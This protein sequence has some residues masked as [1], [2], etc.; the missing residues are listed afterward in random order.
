MFIIQQNILK[1]EIISAMLRWRGTNILVLYIDKI[2]CLQITL[3]YRIPH[4]DL[5][6]N[7][8]KSL[9]CGTSFYGSSFIPTSLNFNLLNKQ[10]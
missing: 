6:L 4:R 9:N 3:Y 1:V 7:H 2:Y 8:R 5:G 10:R